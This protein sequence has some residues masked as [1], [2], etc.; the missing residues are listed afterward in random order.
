MGTAASPAE[1]TITDFHAGQGGDVL[2]LSD[3]LVDEE[4]HQLDEYLHFNF[5]DGDTTVEISSEANGDVTQKVTL[6]GVDLSSMGSSDSEIIS[7]L[8]DDGNLQV[9]Q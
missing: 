6:K 9:D 3:V 4:N 2:D 8:L 1:D 7:N 5:A